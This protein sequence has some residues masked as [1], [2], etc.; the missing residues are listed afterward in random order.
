[1][2]THPLASLTPEQR[3]RFHT[4][5]Y[6]DALWAVTQWLSAERAL[7]SGEAWQL[8]EETLET[9]RQDDAAGEEP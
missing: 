4:Q 8:A 5:L 2:S 9:L 1:M 3:A 7:P 6:N